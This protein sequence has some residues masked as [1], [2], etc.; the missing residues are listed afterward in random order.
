VSPDTKHEP[1]EVEVN[2]KFE[3]LSAPPLVSANVVV[4][5]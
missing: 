5:A 4:K 2:V 1:L 3:T